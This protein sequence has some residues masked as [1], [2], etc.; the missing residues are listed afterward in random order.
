MSQF[1]VKR[2]AYKLLKQDALASFADN[3]FTRMST[4]P[5]YQ[6]FTA[7]VAVLGEK[8]NLYKESLAQAV[9]G[10]IDRITAKNDRQADV[11][12][13]LDTIGDALN[14]SYTGSD[15]WIV[16]TGMELQRE[17]SSTSIPLDPPFD[18]RVTTG[19]SAGEISLSFRVAERKRILNNAIEYS[20]DGGTTWKNGKYTSTT[21]VRL[22][23]LPSRQDML[24]RVRSLGSLERQSGWSKPV[25]VFVV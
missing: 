21:R 20:F 7:A 22:S 4:M 19:G 12:K 13:A 18:L 5:E 24:F 1:I 10:G 17:R 3:V 6:Q 25:E 14:A 15:M 8:L 9:N 16:N 2:T 11:F 23:G